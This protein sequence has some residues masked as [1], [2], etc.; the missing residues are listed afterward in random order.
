MD[1]IFRYYNLEPDTRRADWLRERCIGPKHTL[2]AIIPSGFE[3]YARIL[4]PAWLAGSLDPQDE[5]AWSE[6]RAGWREAEDLKPVR[7][8]TVAADN[9]RVAH[10]LMQ[11]HDISTPT[12]REPGMAGIDPP[13][14]GGLTPEMVESLFEILIAHSGESQE[15]L[16]GFWEGC[17]RD[18]SSRTKVKFKPCVDGETYNLF[19]TTLAGAQSGWL[20]AYEY[21]LRNHGIGTNG[22]APNMVWPTT[23]DWYLAVEYNLHS[24]YI[25]GSTRLIDS[26]SNAGDFETYEALPGDKVF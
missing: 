4:H 15:V 22:L 7:W 3:S 25:G 6:L 18:F 20:A 14:E 8:D 11:W 21:S 16:C 23:R 10:R 17:A 13:L 9:N 1:E 19:N 12:T 24:T 26:I 2:H 5:K